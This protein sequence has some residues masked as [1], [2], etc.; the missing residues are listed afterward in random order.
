MLSPKERKGEKA[1]TVVQ[2]NEEQNW[3]DR[4]E[5]THS[6]IDALCQKWTKSKFV[7]LF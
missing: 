5:S 4:T 1:E 6:L 2:K 7:F 3:N